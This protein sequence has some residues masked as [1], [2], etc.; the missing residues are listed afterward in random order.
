MA[1]ERILTAPR[2]SENQRFTREAPQH[3]KPFLHCCATRFA[4]FT[5][6]TRLEEDDELEKAQVRRDLQQN[7]DH[8]L[9]VMGTPRLLEWAHEQVDRIVA[10]IELNMESEE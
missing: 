6:R 10:R 4:A 1:P 3:G 7:S 2:P 9:D 8:D 5:S